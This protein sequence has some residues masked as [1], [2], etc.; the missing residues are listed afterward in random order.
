MSAT[1]VYGLV[2][3]GA[4][5]P[6]GLAGLDRAPVE[7]VAYEGVAALVSA[8]PA[9]RPLGTREDLLAHEKVVDTVAAAV[10][11]LPVRFGSVVDRPAVVDELL[12]P[13]V[14]ELSSTLSDLD[15]HVQYSVKGRYEREVVL[16]EVV[17]ANPDIAELREQV[18]GMSEEESYQDR[19]RLGELVVAALEE[20]SRRDGRRMHEAL[21]VQAASSVTRPSTDPEQVLDS[22]FLV[23]RDR[24]R[25]FEHAVEQLGSELAGTVRFR[26]VGP[27]APYDFVAPEG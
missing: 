21:R 25:E 20:R 12:A 14:A 13:H 3:A 5:L 23:A 26:L 7:L 27:L 16:R 22:A 4:V 6:D 19:M 15:G 1:Y 8:A 18:H 24:G 9:D 11:V 10:T 2:N 17:L